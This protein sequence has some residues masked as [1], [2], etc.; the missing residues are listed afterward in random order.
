MFTDPDVMLRYIQDPRMC[1]RQPIFLEESGL[2]VDKYQTQFRWTTVY[3]RHHGMRTH[4]VAQRAEMVDKTIRSQCSNLAAF[5]L[6]FDDAKAYAREFNGPEIMQC[7][8]FRPGTYIHKTRYE[9]GV[10][11]KL[12]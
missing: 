1:V 11:R 4:I 7:T 9:P 6:P 3:A 10:V 5:G 12:F 2:S 8:T